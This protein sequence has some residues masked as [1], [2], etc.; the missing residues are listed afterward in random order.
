M[1]TKKNPATALGID[2]N[3]EALLTYSLTFITGIAFLLLEKKNRV[4]RFH[5][6]QSIATFL[7][8]F[9]LVKIL[10]FI[11]FLGWILIPLAMVG[12]TILWVVLMVKA[13][14]GEKFKLPFVGDIAE[15]ESSK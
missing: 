8:I 5:A 14:Q 10:S 9:V 7:G 12:A 6:I 1:E 11:P 3:I 2:E 15:R 4:V 13:Y